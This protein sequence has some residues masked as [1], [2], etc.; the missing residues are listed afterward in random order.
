M[1]A[2]FR[3]RPAFYWCAIFCGVDRRLSTLL[4][5]IY[6]LLGQLFPGALLF[7]GAV[8]VAIARLGPG[9]K[10]CR[11]EPLRGDPLQMT[12]PANAG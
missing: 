7:R 2:Y 8:W 6:E 5:R 1:S 9:R 10:K 12:K 11:T 4:V 3:G